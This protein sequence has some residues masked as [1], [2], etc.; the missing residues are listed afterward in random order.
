MDRAMARIQVTLIK[1]SDDVLPVVVELLDEAANIVGS[2]T[3]AFQVLPAP[4][5]GAIV[6]IV[7]LVA[8]L[9]PLLWISGKVVHGLGGIVTGLSMLAK[10]RVGTKIASALIEPILTGFKGLAAKIAA[11]VGTALTKGV[12]ALMGNAKVAGA[13]DKLGGFMGSK[14]ATGLSVAFAAAAWA[15]VI[16]THN[17]IKGELAAQNTQIDENLAKVLET[18]TTAEVEAALAALESGLVKIN[19]TWD[20]GI[21]TTDSRRRVE[22]NIDAA[23]ENLIQRAAGFGPAIGGALEDGRGAVEQGAAAMTGGIDDQVNAASA[24]AVA[25]GQDIPESIAKG[26]I[27]KQNLPVEALDGLKQLM[28]DALTPGKRIARDIGILISDELAKG[29]KD[30]RPVVREEAERVRAVAEKDLAELILAGGKVGEKAAEKLAKALKD[31]NPQVRAAAQRIQAIVTGEL[32]KTEKPAGDAGAAAAAAF[33]RKLVAGMA[34]LSVIAKLRIIAGKGPTE[35][36]SGG[37]IRAGIPYLVNENTPRSEVI[38]PSTS[39]YVMTY[40]DAVKAVQGASGGGASQ[41]VNVNV[42]NPVPEPASTSTR[43]ELRKLALSGSPE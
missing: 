17:R 2:L 4:V 23:K 24:A 27:E 15:M 32:Q 41:T 11:P 12:E 5:R 26:I 36:A 18:G 25:A 33:R 29:L 22:A 10:S 19:E 31:K 40:A 6:R 43:R 30:R 37:P 38:V 8:A 14:L 28:K 42:Y 7:A 34:G 16:E 35:R 39:G 1:L 9:G 21:F 13:F 3:D 20:A